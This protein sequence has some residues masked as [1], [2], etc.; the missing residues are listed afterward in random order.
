MFRI[1]SQFVAV[2]MVCVALHAPQVA[3]AA[4]PVHADAHG[5]AAHTPDG[6]HGDAHA[7]GGH[8]EHGGLPMTFSK[9]LA[10]FSLI[11]FAV[12]LVVLRVGAWGPL[13]AG[14]S[15]RERGIQQ[16]IADAEVS[17]TKA[18]ALLKEHELKLAKV[19]EEVRE[20][21]AEA[22]RDAEHTKQE[23][24]ATAQKEAD[25]SR[26]RAIADIERS[27]DQALTELFD[28][29]STNVVNA[30][31]NVIGRSLS[32]DDHDRLVKEALSQIN[33]RRN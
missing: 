6:A 20:I 9:D 32:G 1:I 33:V 10:F 19:Q 3:F 7:E 22:R 12:Y 24:L 5:D 25:A 8:G 26:Q 27:R 4:D 29:V 23:I 31:E 18:E 2:A 15:E 14:L 16:N 17:R 11:T 13:R 30:T 28:F 21:L